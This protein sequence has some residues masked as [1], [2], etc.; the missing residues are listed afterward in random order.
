MVSTLSGNSAE[1]TCLDTIQ[2]GS[3]GSP[4]DGLSSKHKDAKGLILIVKILH[5]F[6]TTVS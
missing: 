1:D 5:K 6:L 3:I 4:C 2:Q